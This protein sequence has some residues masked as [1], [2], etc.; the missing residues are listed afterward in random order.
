M[1]GKGAIR[2]VLL[3]LSKQRKNAELQCDGFAA[4]SALV[5]EVA[6]H[7]ELLIEHDTLHT[8]VLRNLQLHARNCELQHNACYMFHMISIMCKDKAADLLEAGCVSHLAN[9]I[10][11]H[12]RH[13]ECEDLAFTARLTI[14]WIVNAHAQPCTGEQKQIASNALARIVREGGVQAMTFNTKIPPKFCTPAFGLF[15]AM[16]TLRSMSQGTESI[17]GSESQLVPSAHAR[18]E[19]ASAAHAQ[20]KAAPKNG[21]KVMEMCVACGKTAAEARVKKLLRCSACTLA[22]RY[23]SVEC[24]HACWAA[25]KAECKANKKPVK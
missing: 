3:A 15:S 21:A 14:S 19:D 16:Q 6:S 18:G 2:A 11:L 22:P 13:S 5:Q 4:I 25:H 8:I 24:N 7:A 20:P 12:E 23:C 10:S 1:L 17:A 9:V